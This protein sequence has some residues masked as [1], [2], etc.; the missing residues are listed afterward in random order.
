MLILAIA[1]P[2]V[3][4]A[5]FLYWLIAMALIEINRIDSDQM[6]EDCHGAIPHDFTG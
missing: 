2:F 4:F 6:K 1:L 5:V 3:A